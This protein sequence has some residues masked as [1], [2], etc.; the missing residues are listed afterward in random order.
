MSAKPLPMGFLSQ[1]LINNRTWLYKMRL[2]PEAPPELNIPIVEPDK[3][4]R[5][6]WYSKEQVQTWLNEI[7][8]YNGDGLRIYFGRKGNEPNPVD[9]LHTFPPAPGQ[10]CL[11][12]VITKPGIER[13]AHTNVVYERQ[14]DYNDRHAATLELERQTGAKGINAGSYRPPMPIPEGPDFPD[15]TLPM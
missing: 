13:D 9:P 12:M 15:E 14:A 1:D 6:V 10:L 11:V 8:H 3:E 2:Q 7:E 4:T 5:S